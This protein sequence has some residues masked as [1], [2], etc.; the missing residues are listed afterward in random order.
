MLYEIQ[1][2]ELCLNIAGRHCQQLQISGTD[3]GDLSFQLSISLM[4]HVLLT[5]YGILF[6]SMAATPVI[7]SKLSKLVSE[8]EQGK[9]LATV[10][11]PGPETL[12]SWNIETRLWGG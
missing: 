4:C 12:S 1:E 5:G 9:E 2:G 6:L 10:L 8:T 7:R 11:K 3:F